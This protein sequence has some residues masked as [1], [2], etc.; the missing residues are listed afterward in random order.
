VKTHTSKT[1]GLR[2]VGCISYQ[3]PTRGTPRQVS[4][5]HDKSPPCT[6][7]L[8]LRLVHGPW[9]AA[10]A[11]GA[12]TTIDACGGAIPHAMQVQQLAAMQAAH[13]DKSLNVGLTG[14][15]AIPSPSSRTLPHTSS[16]RHAQAPSTMCTGL[17]LGSSMTG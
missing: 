6:T 4:A 16:A 15:A 13:C 10:L 17:D 11:Q 14:C 1:S 9:R 5:S 8:R 3:F 12:S 7:T 2:S